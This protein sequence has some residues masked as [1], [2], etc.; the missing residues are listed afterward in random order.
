MVW[1]SR[2]LSYYKVFR[3]ISKLISSG[4]IGEARLEP[5]N[6]STPEEKF[7]VPYQRNHKFTGRCNLLSVL[8]SR[9]CCE[10][11]RAW[12][13]RIALYGLGGVGKTQLALEYVHSQKDIYDRIYWISAA[14]E[15][16]L[17]SGFQQI[18]SQTHWVHQNASLQPKEV[19]AIVLNQLRQRENWLLVFDNLDDFEL[20]DNCLPDV[21][22]NKHTLITTRNPNCHQIPAEGLEVGVLDI[23]DA[24]EFLL[25]RSNITPAPPAKTEASNIVKELGCL[26]LAVEQAAAYIRETLKDIFKYLSSYRRS[27]RSHHERL[28][29]A[30]RTYYEKSIATTWS[31]SFLRLS[32]DAS[33]LLRVLSFLNP[34]GILTDFLEAGQEGLCQPLN[35]IFD[36]IDRRCEALSELERFSLIRRQDEAN[37]GELIT[38]HRLVQSVVKDDLS[39]ELFAGMQANAVRLCI[40]GFPEGDFQYHP[41]LVRCRRFYGQVVG[42]LST[43]KDI[44]HAKLGCL[45]HRLG[46]FLVADGKFR[47][48][49]IILERAR[50]T[51]DKVLEKESPCIL[52]TATDLAWAYYE[53]GQLQD[54][55]DLAEKVLT[56]RQALDGE[57]QSEATLSIMGGV[58][59]LYCGQG[60]YTLAAEMQRKVADN[61]KSLLG[62]HHRDTL[63]AVEALSLIYV[64]QGLWTEAAELQEEVL[65]SRR[66]VF[67]DDSLLTYA[68]MTN[69]AGI[70]QYQGR[71]EAARTLT[72]S[73][74]EARLRLLGNHPWT[75]WAQ[76]SLGTVW[77]ECGRLQD[78]LKMLLHASDGLASTLGTKHPMTLIAM[79]NLGYGYSDQRIFDKSI[80][81]LEVTVANSSKVSGTEH[82]YT[83]WMKECLAEVYHRQGYF[84]KAICLLEIVVQSRRTVLGE[85]HCITLANESKLQRWRKNAG[86]KSKSMLVTDGSSFERWGC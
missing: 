8:R 77:A 9:L 6:V 20:L 32:A 24:T 59:G 12:N 31:M 19:V 76:M 37:G 30:N 80:Q 39:E 63:R 47:E 14:S 83:L 78:S 16:A 85:S 1:D 43:I 10:K 28:S 15:E 18:A 35:E 21:G 66:R 4:A 3:L 74:V 7:I 29:K 27:Q 23:D 53:S 42:L 69:L 51:M 46:V 34:D 52:R 2:F 57:E 13:H 84:E 86:S 65:E 45:L 41:T 61:S 40:Y 44:Q 72:E 49:V 73:T 33:A 67:G 48:A 71:F 70:Y 58:A 36:D 54:S 5:P 82:F 62:P 26:P 68:A 25:T 75:F 38:M 60:R 11:V 79:A 64:L 50:S 81:V 56:T 17:I 22:T 55:L